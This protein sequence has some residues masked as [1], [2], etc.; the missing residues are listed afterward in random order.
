M[1]PS[2]TRTLNRTAR[3]H[4]YVQ[5]GLQLGCN[6][7]NEWGNMAIT[8]AY[9]WRKCGTGETPLQQLMKEISKW[10]PSSECNS[11]CVTLFWVIFE[12]PPVAQLL[13]NSATFC[14]TRESHRVYKSSLLV[15]VLS[16]ANPDH[17]TP[18]YPSEIHFNI[19][20]PSMSSWGEVK[21]CWKSSKIQWSKVKSGR[22]RWNAVEV[23]ADHG[24]MWVQQF[25]IMR[26]T[27]LLLF[28]V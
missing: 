7:Q 12:K 6:L 5:T 27:I 8:L 15:A 2:P 24:A 21:V 23:R 25:G 3:C 28:S 10:L 22:R 18:S 4:Q 9:V 14:G 11:H 1:P 17:T 20:L 13:K 16:Q 19:I 26:L